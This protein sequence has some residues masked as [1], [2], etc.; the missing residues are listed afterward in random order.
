MLYLCLWCLDNFL[1]DYP[2]MI[3][4]EIDDAWRWFGYIC[5]CVSVLDFNPVFLRG[6]SSRSPRLPKPA[7]KVPTMTFDSLRRISKIW[8]M[9]SPRM[10]RQH[11][12]L[13]TCV[14][15]CVRIISM[16][17]MYCVPYKTESYSERAVPKQLWSR[18]TFVPRV[19][20]RRQF[21]YDAW[22]CIYVCS[23]WYKRWKE[24][25]DIW[26]VLLTVY[27]RT[28]GNMHT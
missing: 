28:L 27:V 24:P 12:S 4:V 9:Q 1:S 22:A 6:S 5:E 16:Y 7:A 21:M 14:Q 23:I 18:R 13:S 20:L 8:N 11:R 2:V 17:D 3:R 26:L 25:H 15:F 10:H 19:R